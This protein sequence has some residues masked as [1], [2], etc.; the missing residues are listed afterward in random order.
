MQVVAL[1]DEENDRFGVSFPD[2]P[3]CT[4]TANDLDGA[5]ARAAQ[6]LAF[7]VEGLAEDGPLPQ[8]RTLDELRKDKQFR[9]DSKNAVVALVPYNPPSRAIRLNITLDEALL[10]RVDRAAEVAGET[11]SGYL[12]R[13][14]S[15]RLARLGGTQPDLVAPPRRRSARV[16]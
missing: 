14:A 12:A 10:G 3:G 15:Q 4:T 11:R 8:P 2:F 16:E 6:V 7:H 5:V 9:M 13:A 1:I